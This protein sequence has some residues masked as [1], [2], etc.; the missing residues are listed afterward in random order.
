M[1]IGVTASALAIATTR[2]RLANNPTPEACR[3]PEK[4]FLHVCHECD[5]EVGV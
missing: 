5:R 2:P 1:I 4:V 3:G